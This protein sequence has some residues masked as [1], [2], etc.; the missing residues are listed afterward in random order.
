ME[1]P[2]TRFAHLL[3]PIRDL[4]KNWEV[5]V[6]SE[7]NDY[8]EE[9]EKMTIT[10]DDGKTRLN[11]AEAALVIQGSAC[12]Y[13]KKVE[14]LHSLVYQ[15]LECISDRNKKQNKQRVQFEDNAVAANS[16]NDDAAEFTPVD[17]EVSDNTQ[18]AVNN[19]L[20]DV[21]PL[22]PECLIPPETHEKQKFPLISAKG[23]ILCSQKD[24][25]INRFI[26]GEDGMIL[27]TPRLAGSRS[28]VDDGRPPAEPLQQQHQDAEAPAD[29]AMDVADVEGGRGDAAENF[30]SLEDNNM[31]LDHV[32]RHQASG[33]GRLIPERQQVEA[34]KLRSKDEA[35]AVSMWTHHDPYVVLGEDKPFKLGKV[36]RVPDGLDNKG[37]RKRAQPAPLQDFS[38]WLEST[39]DCR[40]ALKNKPTFKGL[41]YIYLSSL[42]HR[43]DARKRILKAAGVVVSD[44]ELRRTY[45]NVDE[46]EQE[47][48]VDQFKP[49]DPLG[50]DD[51]DNG[52]EVFPNN[53][54]A[55]A[56]VSP[57]DFISTEA[58]R[59]EMTYEDLVQLRVDQLVAMCR[60]YNQETDL[61][62]RVKEWEDRI[63]PELALQEQQPP[64]NIHK[65]G[66]RI[67]EALGKVS[68]R[69][70]FSSIVYGLDNLEASRYLLASL[71]LANDYTVEI[72]SAEGLEH[73][74]DS[75]GLTLLSSEKATDRFKTLPSSQ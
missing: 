51:D 53:T 72:D 41:D 13:S 12:I 74:L 31:E 36:Y 45:L 24:F 5:D 40:H 4:T 75:M 18:K 6:A 49:V 32:D 66:D 11:F 64:F 67:V 46:D 50:G 44:E 1:P 16:Y 21:T 19:K 43:L 56:G 27:L 42:K 28:L 68:Q 69:R 62:R 20:V 39:N 29:A 3:Q 65:Y 58:L 30:L 47:G 15:T 73:S 14:L 70:S 2:D 71:Q 52:P 38:G 54:Q 37:K 22:P 60:D 59:D 57:A 34:D 35:P 7:L 61:S 8:L 9:L 10:F 23:E 25:W 63:R 33:E 55:S 48:P 26:P 17:I